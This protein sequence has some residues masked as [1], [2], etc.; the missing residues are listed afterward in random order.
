MRL[1][2]IELKNWKNFQ[3]VDVAL[4]ERVFVIG[5]N[6][7]GKSNLLDALRFL[8][9]VA[10]D[11]LRPAIDRRDGVS[12]IRNLNARRDPE[13]SLSV[14]LGD[15]PGEDEWRYELVIVQ[16]NQR[17]PQVRREVVTRD[18]IVLLK[19]P[20]RDDDNDRLRLSQTHLEQV[21]ANRSFRLVNEF[22]SS[23]SYLHLVPQIIRDTNRLLSVHND[24]FGSD[25]LE[26]IAATPERTRTARL[27][28]INEALRV[29]VPQLRDL[30]FERDPIDG[31]PHLEGTFLHWRPNARRQRE[32]QFSDG[33]LR[34]LGLLWA[35]LEGTGPLVLEEPELSLHASIVREI[36]RLFRRA[37][38]ISHRGSRQVLITTHSFD[39]LSDE[40]IDPTEVLVLSPE[41]EATTVRAAADIQSIRD[42]VEGGVSVGEAALPFTAPRDAFQLSLFSA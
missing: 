6:A 25:F 34:L 14:T 28:R 21:S 12:R 35:L 30:H 8:Q 10:S 19:R 26:R 13:I 31:A 15:E 11:G 17:Q 38:R 16:D 2:R 23:I 27:K 41:S 18:G 3:Q 7:S 40:G 37:T 24:P 39:L 1:L 29:A 32:S 4:E 20:D 22:L 42:L 36:P 9:E 5:P 33:T